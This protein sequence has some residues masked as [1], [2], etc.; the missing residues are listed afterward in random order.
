ML[1][2]N[3][4]MTIGC[5]W[6]TTGCYWLTIGYYWMTV[7][8]YWITIGCYWM[9]IGCL[10]NA[11]G[12]PWA[13]YSFFTTIVNLWGTG[14]GIILSS[15]LMVPCQHHII[16]KCPHEQG[17]EAWS[18]WSNDDSSLSTHAKHLSGSL[19]DTVGLLSNSLLL[20]FCLNLYVP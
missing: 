12:W 14:I 9:T 13:L 7:R 20:L 15:S 6:M 11:I 16:W 10:L 17:S 2:N 1:L 18:L 4:W 3:S 5:C 8:C 19:A